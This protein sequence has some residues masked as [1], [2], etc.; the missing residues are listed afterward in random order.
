M[1]L[2]DSSMTV[3]PEVAS[4]IDEVQYQ[5]HNTST[6]NNTE[7]YV[8]YQLAVSFG[9]SKAIQERDNLAKEL[10][11]KDRRMAKKKADEEARIAAEQL[12]EIELQAKAKKAEE[13]SQAEEAAAKAKAAVNASAQAILSLTAKVNAHASSAVAA[14]AKAL[15]SI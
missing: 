7:A 11:R 8:W 1:T 9:D 5:I 13:A 15:A 14:S 3:Q 2:S 10:S 12:K 4:K 6:E